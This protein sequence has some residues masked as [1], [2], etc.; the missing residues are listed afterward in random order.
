MLKVPDNWTKQEHRKVKLGYKARAILFSSISDNMFSNVQHC[1]TAKEIWEKLCLLYEGDEQVKE[2]IVSRLKQEYGAFK[3]G[4]REPLE[5][6]CKRFTILLLK[7]RNNGVTI[8]QKDVNDKF[9]RSMPMRFL[10]KTVTIRQLREWKTISSEGLYGDLKAY[11]M[12]YEKLES[13][14]KLSKEESS[15]RMEKKKKMRNSWKNMSKLR[16]K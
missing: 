5:S 4:Y 3:C 14:E 11:E 16:E 6:I 7:L 15:L 8:P 2:N 1:T 9:L 12:Q 13:S 10:I